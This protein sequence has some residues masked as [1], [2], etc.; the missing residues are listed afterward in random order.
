MADSFLASCRLAIGSPT[1][2][3][4][5][6]ILALFLFDVDR[7]KRI[8]DE[9]GHGAGDEVLRAIGSTLR[10]TCRPYDTPC[11][12]GGDEFAIL[13]PRCDVKAGARI[14]H[15]VCWSVFQYCFEYDQQIFRIGSSIGLKEWTANSM[16]VEQVIVEADA[17]CYKG[18]RKGRNRVELADHLEC[19][20]IAPIGKD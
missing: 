4:V 13:L 2:D 18:K 11:R 19:A 7:F 10:K 16:G 1:P 5:Y 17:A 6:A 15:D 3:N 8:N 12:Y 14:A 20:G 9:R